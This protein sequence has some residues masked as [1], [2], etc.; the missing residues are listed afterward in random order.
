MDKYIGFDID[1]NKTI[2]CVMQKGK[3][4]MYTTLKTDIGQMKN[5]LQK[6]RQDGEKLYLTFEILH[7]DM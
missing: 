2:A 1:S 6:Q 4:D 3:K 7:F 5:F